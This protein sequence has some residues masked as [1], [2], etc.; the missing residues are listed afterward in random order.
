MAKL[1]LYLIFFVILYLNSD[2]EKRTAFAIYYML[3]YLIY[4]IADT[5][6]LLNIFKE[7]K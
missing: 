3:T 1:F 2:T 4:A 6:S 5:T 7:E